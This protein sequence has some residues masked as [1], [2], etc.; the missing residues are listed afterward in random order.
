MEDET[1][2][3]EA[4]PKKKKRKLPIVVGVVVLVLIV[5]GAGFWIWHE[6]PSFCSTVCHQPMNTY[7]ETYYS[8]DSSL[9]VTSHKSADKACLDC[10]EARI[11]TQLT[12]AI[13][14]LS[15]SY[16]VNESGYLVSDEVI[17]TQDFCERCHD[18]EEVKATTTE[19]LTSGTKYINPH[20]NHLSSN[21]ECGDCHKAHE[22]SVL[23][24]NSCHGWDLPDG[25]VNPE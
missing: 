24:C 12:E 21:L 3:V 11:D 18:F 17:G 10:H 16:T 14:W 4:T 6:Q 5:A 20:D 13:S 25:W 19:A 9:L 1:K 23:Y 7:V 15:G 22:Q 2:N 8:D